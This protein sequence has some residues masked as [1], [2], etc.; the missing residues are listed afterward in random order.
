MEGLEFAARPVLESVL[1]R[2]ACKEAW[3]YEVRTRGRN[4]TALLSPKNQ[5]SLSHAVLN[6]TVFSRSLP[7]GPSLGVCGRSLWADGRVEPAAAQTRVSVLRELGFIVTGLVSYTEVGMGLD[8]PTRLTRHSS[9]HALI[10]AGFPL[11]YDE[12]LMG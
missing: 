7:G 9:V 8:L 10:S 11:P 12:A 1:V 2:S 5:L 3:A 4:P 6:I